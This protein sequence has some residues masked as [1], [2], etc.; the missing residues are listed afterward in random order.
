MTDRHFAKPIQA[1]AILALFLSAAVRPASALELPSADYPVAI[2]RTLHAPVEST[3]RAV[4]QV[5]KS[6][7][8][9]LITTD[10]PSGLLVFGIPANPGGKPTY[11]NVLMEPSALGA[12]TVVYLVP[13]HRH[14][15]AEAG[16]DAAFFKQLQSA[17]GGIGQ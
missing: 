2:Q 5:M 9:Y 6:R 16:S 17:V 10:K 4:M 15:R 1:F 12:G 8:G 3:W 14:G 7:N 11:Y 13:R